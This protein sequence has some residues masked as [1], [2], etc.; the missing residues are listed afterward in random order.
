MATRGQSWARSS[1][2]TLARRLRRERALAA[3]HHA[4]DAVAPESLDA[5]EAELRDRLTCIAPV[6]AV[7]LGLLEG[8]GPVPKQPSSTKRARR[9]LSEHNFQ[10]RGI[11]RKTGAEAKQLQ[12]AGAGSR[13]SAPA[14]GPLPARASRLR[15]A[16]APFLPHSSAG[17]SFQ[18][19]PRGTTSPA[20]RSRPGFRA[21]NGAPRSFVE[22][23]TVAAP[24][25]LAPSPSA[26]AGMA[27]ATSDPI[28]TWREIDKSPF[29]VPKH[30]TLQPVQVIWREV[31]VH[32]YM[33]IEVARDPTAPQIREILRDESSS[34][35]DQGENELRLARNFG[36]VLPGDAYATS[37]DDEN[38]DAWDPSTRASSFAAA[39]DIASAQSGDEPLE[40]VNDPWR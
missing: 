5:L 17:S 11:S 27:H 3:V 8:D 16:A 36:M 23:P 34:R 13:G 14:S 29:K 21:K 12:R 10:V 37:D 35:S 4:V 6:L 22:I 31:V 15:A 38:G 9:N 24:L 2:R 20:T 18:T 40:A 25:A 26:P 19:T 32:K 33:V 28:T 30:V 39:E 1:G 7:R